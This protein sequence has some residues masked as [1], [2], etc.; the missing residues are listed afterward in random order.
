M[1]REPNQ[2]ADAEFRKLVTAMREAQR[3]YL[4]VKTSFNLTAAK[5]LEHAVDIALRELSE[6]D[7]QPG[8]ADGRR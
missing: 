8:E 1:I 2:P 6:A 3:K 5:R 7:L 4:L